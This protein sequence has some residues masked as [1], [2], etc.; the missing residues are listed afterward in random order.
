MPPLSERHGDL[1][2]LIRAF[3]RNAAAR[4]GKAA[5]AITL[6]AGAFLETY[7][8]PGNIRELQNMIFDAVSRNNGE[9]LSVKD[10]KPYCLAA[11]F[12]PERKQDLTVGSELSGFAETDPP[13]SLSPKSIKFP[14]PLPTIREVTDELVAEAMRRAGKNQTKAAA[15]LGISQPALNKRLKNR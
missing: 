14:D 15:L 5:P 10:F 11:H 2:I 12:R 13:D 7:L 4:L 6:S 9:S 3:I 1:P 8:F